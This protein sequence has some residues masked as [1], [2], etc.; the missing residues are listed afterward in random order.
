MI[1]AT[2]Y[3]VL[4]VILFSLGVIG[5]LVRRNL[6]VVLMSLELIFNAVNL[7]LVAFSDRL[8]D[9]GGQIFAVFVITVAAAEAAESNIA[10]SARSL[11]LKSFLTSRLTPR[12]SVAAKRAR[13]SAWGKI[14]PTGVL[15]SF[16]PCPS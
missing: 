13:L 15:A 12:P 6:I 11:D 5:V 14:S 2:H 3:L 4:S 1:G 8:A 9:L 7:N 16:C 10:A